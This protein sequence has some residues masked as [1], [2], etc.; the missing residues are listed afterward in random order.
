MIHLIN[1]S[2]FFRKQIIELFLDFPET[3]PYIRKRIIPLIV[4]VVVV[5]IVAGKGFWKNGEMRIDVW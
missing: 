3:I 1:A 2:T 4:V 5:V